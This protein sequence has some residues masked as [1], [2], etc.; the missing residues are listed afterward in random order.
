MAWAMFCSSTVL[1]VRGGDT[2]RARWPLPIGAMRSITRVEMSSCCCGVVPAFLVSVPVR[3]ELTRPGE[4]ALAVLGRADLAFDRIAGAQAEFA[5]L[6]R[7]H[8]DVI[9]AR[10]VVGFHRAQVA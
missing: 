1:P 9:G 4:V 7:A 2:I 5:D 6:G 3:R 10:Q 8:I